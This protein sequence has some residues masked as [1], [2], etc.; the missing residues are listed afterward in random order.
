MKNHAACDRLLHSTGAQ[1]VCGRSLAKV[2]LKKKRRRDIRKNLYILQFTLAWMTSMP[3]V[4]HTP[5]SFPKPA[6]QGNIS[7]GAK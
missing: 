1:Q 7:R 6:L 2:K 3:S 4:L 5:T